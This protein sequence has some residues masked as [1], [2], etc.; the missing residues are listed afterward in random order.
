[1][2]YTADSDR[3]GDVLAKVRS[4]WG[5]FVALGAVLLLLG[6]VALGNLVVATV[7]SIFAIGIIMIAGGI[8]HII[9]AFR[10]RGGRSFVGW[11][12]GGLLYLLAGVLVFADPALASSVLTLFI[13]FALIAAGAARIWLGF[14][15]RP[16]KGWGWIVAA[17]VVTILAGLVI[18]TGWPVNSLWVIGLFL[19]VDL[20]FQGWSYIAIGLALRARA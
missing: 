4:N 15:M 14:A 16:A 2:T 17:G 1:M 8:A 18:A 19:G 5:W 11:L 10:G 6:L 12:L 13:A 7:A 3:L 20:L 9:L